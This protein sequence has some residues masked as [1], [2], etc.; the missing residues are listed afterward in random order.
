VVSKRLA[1]KDLEYNVSQTGGQQA[2]LTCRSVTRLEWDIF[3][4]WSTSTMHFVFTSR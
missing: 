4:H 3:F 2:A 1:G